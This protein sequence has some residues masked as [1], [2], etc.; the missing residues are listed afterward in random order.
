MAISAPSVPEKTNVPRFKSNFFAE[1]NEGNLM[2]KTFIAILILLFSLSLHLPAQ[3]QEEVIKKG[4]ALDMQRCIRIGLARHPAILSAA[5]TVS[6]NESRIGQARSGYLPQVG[7]SA[8]ISRTDP[9]TTPVG[10]VAQQSGNIY[11]QY[12]SSITLNQNIYDFGKTAAQVDVQKLNT[13]S[14]RLDL[15]AVRKQIVFNVKQAYLNLL[16]SQKNLEVGLEKVQQFQKHLDQA[17]G[18]FEV[19]VKPKFDV[20][21]A[22]VDLS[23]ARLDL[24]KAENALRISRSTLNNAMGFP[25]APEYSISRADFVPQPYGIIFEEAL[26]KA[27]LDRPELKSLATKRLAQEKTIELSKK[28]YYPNVTGTAGYGWGGT[29][30]VGFGGGGDQNFPW[31]QGWNIGA[32]LNIPIFSGLSTKYQVDEARASLEVI[33]ANE[34]TLR[35]DIYL[36]LQQSY[37][38]LREATD[39]ITTTELAV[40]QAAE[41]MELANG[42]YAS[43][44]GSPIEITDALVAHSNAQTAQAAAIYDHKIAQASIEKAIGFQ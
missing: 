36:E 13:G 26:Q 21:K 27:Y 9:Y 41:N 18:F 19:G 3:G 5:S 23:N 1:R 17:K 31:D 6:V 11:N 44:V 14:S 40:R 22:E 29:N 33:K 16:K 25:D 28:G 12:V 39:R 4:E 2:R 24:L 34:K 35:Q 30:T 10:T 42:R 8:T 32:T 20:T 7:A 43:G 38:N 37:S 15:D